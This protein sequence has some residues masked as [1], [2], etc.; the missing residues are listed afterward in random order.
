MLQARTDLEDVQERMQEALSAITRTE[1][2]LAQS[3]QERV[4]LVADAEIERERDL[5]ATENEIAQEWVMLATSRHLV[6][7]ITKKAYNLPGA[8]QNLTFQV[9]RRTAAGPDQFSADE[10]TLLQPGDLIRISSKI[11]ATRAHPAQVDRQ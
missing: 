10:A 7:A 9:V 5:V 3:E 4:K 1:L 8:K 11:E 2:R 6:S